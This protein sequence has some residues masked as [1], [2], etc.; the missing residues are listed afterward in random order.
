[1]T[2][3]FLSHAIEDSNHARLLEAALQTSGVSCWLFENEPAAGRHHTHNTDE[4]VHAS[5]AFVL[6]MS[7]HSVGSKWV[8]KELQ[9]AAAAGKPILPI[10][11]DH[12]WEWFLATKERWRRILRKTTA[13][14]AIDDLGMKKSAQA[15]LRGLADAG[16]PCSGLASSPGRGEAS[17]PSRQRVVPA[18]RSGA[19][20]HFQDRVGEMETLRGLLG[21]MDVRFVL[22]HG[23]GGMGKT[24]LV[25][26]LVGDFVRDL[27]EGDAGAARSPVDSIVR[28]DLE[29][30]S[31]PSPM[32]II[33]MV[34]ETFEPDVRQDFGRACRDAKPE[35]ALDLLFGKLLAR[36][37]RLIVLD[38]FE[39][40]LDENNRIRGEHA[41]LGKMIE[42]CLEIDHA[43]L[44]MATSCRRL[45]L[46][47]EVEGKLGRRKK[48]V[49]LDALPEA[50]ARMVLR[51][52]DD[53]GV[54]GL[55]NADDAMLG[56]VVHACYRVPRTLV[57]LVGTLRNLDTTLPAFLEDESAL[58]ALAEDPARELY[59][60]LSDDEQKPVVEALAVFG[61]PVPAAALKHV[62]PSLPVERIL[63]SLKRCHAVSFEPCGCLYSLHPMDPR[64]VYDTLGGKGSGAS[65]P[66]LHLA[67]AGWY[68]TRLR[69]RSE[70]KAYAD[71]EPQVQQIQHLTRAGHCDQACELLTSIDREYLAVWGFYPLLIQLRQDLEGKLS[72][73]RLRS[74]NRGDLGC[75]LFETNKVEEARVLYHQALE[76][77]QT[78]GLRDLEC[79]WIGNLGIAADSP[80]EGK[81]LLQ[82]GLDLAKE[83]GDRRHEGRWLGKVTGLRVGPLREIS[84]AEAIPLLV[85]AL[86]IA[87]KVQ[88][89]RFAM[90]WLLDMYR[91]H[92][93]LQENDE[94]IRCLGE[95][96]AAA[97]IIGHRHFQADILFELH[98]AKWAL[99]R[100]DEAM[101]DLE[102]AVPTLIQIGEKKATR[103]A[104]MVL[105][106]HYKDQ[107]HPEKALPWYERALAFSREFGNKADEGAFLNGLGIAYYYLKD[108]RKAIES[109]EQGLEIARS[110]SDPDLE[111][112]TLYNVGDCWHQLGELAKAE[113]LYRASRTLDRVGTSYICAY[114]LACIA[115]TLKDG[116]EAR[117]RMDECVLLCR[118]ALENPGLGHK[119]AYLMAL[120][121]LALGEVESGLAACHEALQKRYTPF[122]VAMALCDLDALKQAAPGLAGFEEMER[123]LRE[124]TPP[125]VNVPGGPAGG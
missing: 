75:S 54:L 31:A 61:Q 68:A 47:N 56:E 82:T 57:S 16:I 51:L 34:L 20:P 103:N 65:R 23:R 115:F 114:G 101:R 2:V 73:P 107:G 90:Y 76:I 50:D 42:K 6:L 118:K 91:L 78:A 48:E 21:N 12:S 15:I 84:G 39:R 102:E 46:S 44:L 36:R 49:N 122:D 26:K 116:A 125:A 22:I 11:L 62:R 97:R 117:K 58:A 85:E 33:D 59:Q 1:M 121:Y 7:D 119:P 10:M 80:E 9:T 8:T 92:R 30:L 17:R 88:D 123:L 104:L 13:Y 77:A 110:L 64:Y 29:E 32:K 124:A 53:D 89:H 99:R 70:W 100:F 67:A 120:A 52:L 86:A 111:A 24:S 25:D 71:V 87:R 40:V 45:A 60:S 95:A 93:S 106:E 96:L 27:L 63:A 113:P 19:L 35:E 108:F 79:R 43:G 5:Q 55:R 37:R 105:A 83:I 28:V 38:S 94:A 14:S 3:V 18:V 41:D 98:N 72:T 66:E 69:P 109:Y 112:I 74:E 81:R 4:A